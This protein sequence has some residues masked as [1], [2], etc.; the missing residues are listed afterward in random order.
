[1][2]AS[3]VTAASTAAPLGAAVLTPP[4][5]FDAAAGDDSYAED[6]EPDAGLA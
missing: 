6:L 2:G 1:M 5:G 4:D 3:V